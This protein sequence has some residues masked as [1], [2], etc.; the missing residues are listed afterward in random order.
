MS[1]TQD[2]IVALTAHGCREAGDGR[3]TLTLLRVSRMSGACLL[4]KIS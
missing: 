4:L 1:I 3:A 2:G